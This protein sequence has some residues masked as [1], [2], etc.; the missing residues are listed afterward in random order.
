MGLSWGIF[1]TTT[2][3]VPVLYFATFCISYTGS[4]HFCFTLQRW[5]SC[6]LIEP[7]QGSC[8]L[9]AVR[10]VTSNQVIRYTYI[11]R[12]RSPLDF[13]AVNVIF[14]T[15]ITVHLRS[16]PLS[17]P[18]HFLD[19]QLSENEFILVAQYQSVTLSN[20]STGNQHHKVV[21]KILLKSLS[22]RPFIYSLVGGETSVI[23]VLLIGDNSFL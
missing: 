9:N 3:S 7:G 19:L 13:T 15:S 21:W 14:D 1:A 5:F 8:R 16:T 2:S 22:D 10:C 4:V 20:Y 6:S 17:I 18:I 23:A 11:S 12:G